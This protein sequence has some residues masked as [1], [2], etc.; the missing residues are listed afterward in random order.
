[1]DFNKVLN[2]VGIYRFIRFKIINYALRTKDDF[3]CPICEY[4]GHFEVVTPHTGSRINAKCPK[5]GSLERHRLQYLVLCDL[6]KLIDFKSKSCLHIAP[7][8]FFKNYFENMFSKYCTA[9]LH[10][11]NVDFNF[12]LCDIPFESSSFD[13]VY[14]SHV[15]EHIFDDTKALKEIKRILRP[16]GIAILPVPILSLSTVEYSEPN[17]S[18]EMHVRAPGT[19]YFE[20]YVQI[21]SH[22]KLYSSS[23]YDPLF[24]TWIYEDRNIYPMKLSPLRQS[25]DGIKHEDFVPVCYV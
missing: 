15:M 19:D 6:A 14:A 3:K 7:E 11:K 23:H 1:M 25:M 2:K 18:E 16:G 12:D 20:R 21:Y 17:P 8:I 5:C 22:V 10:S 4:V 9:D 13:V 24:Q